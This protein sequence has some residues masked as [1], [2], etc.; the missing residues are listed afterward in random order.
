[1][2]VV[3]GPGG[4]VS[5]VVAG[6]PP[7]VAS[8][9]RHR[10]RTL[11]SKQY[12]R[13]ASLVIARLGGEPQQACWDDF[14]RA[15][16]A[17]E[18]LLNDGGALAICANSITPPGKSLQRLAG[19]DD[20]E[21]IQRHLAR[22]CHADTWSAWQLARALDRG[23]VYLLSNLDAEIVEDLGVAPV[24]DVEELA[25]LASRHDSCI[26]LDDAQYVVADV[27]GD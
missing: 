5:S 6:A 23:P 27:K 24:H 4:S 18:P 9:A 8:A 12:P 20:L 1:M 15:L 21:S 2:E 16:V 19:T 11:W 26:V 17:A 22:D 3:P 14:G 25:R 7:A 10:C 13:R